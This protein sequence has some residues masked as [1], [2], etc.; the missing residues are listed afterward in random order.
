M[1]D[2]QPLFLALDQGG[3]SSR[4]LVLTATGDVVAKAQVPISTQTLGD[5]RVEHSAEELAH[6]LL[7]CCDEVAKLLAQAMGLTSIRWSGDQIR[8][9]RSRIAHRLKQVRSDTMLC[10]TSSL[11]ETSQPRSQGPMLYGGKGRLQ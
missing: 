2:G 1:N 9:Y 7:T 10:P 11:T 5:T 6:S 3:H 8:A 4:A